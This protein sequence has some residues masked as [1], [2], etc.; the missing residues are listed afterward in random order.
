ME[1]VDP[2]KVDDVAGSEWK[3]RLYG[4][5]TVPPP[6]ADVPTFR[7]V[8][9]GGAAAALACWLGV[10]WLI[11]AVASTGMTIGSFVAPLLV[12]LP[13]VVRF[14]VS[15]FTLT[16]FLSFRR[17]YWSRR[18]TWAITLGCAAVAVVASAVVVLLFPRAFLG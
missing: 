5:L 13:I 1:A 16:P 2:F 11:G 12:F 3:Y 14:A 8:Y 6:P 18:K 4:L 17:V 10:A 7:F 9:A 15:V